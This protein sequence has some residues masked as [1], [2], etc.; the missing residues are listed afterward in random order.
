MN[1]DLMNRIISQLRTRVV[2]H[3]EQDSQEGCMDAQLR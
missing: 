3:C 1:E 2:L